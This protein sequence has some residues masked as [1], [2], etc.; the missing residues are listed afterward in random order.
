MAKFKVGD[1]VKF[2]GVDKWLLALCKGDG[3]DWTDH[4][5]RTEV[6]EVSEVDSIDNFIPINSYK[7]KG[8]PY[9]FHED[10]LKLVKEAEK[11]AKSVGNLHIKNVIFNDMATIVFWSDGDKTVVLCRRGDSYD[12]EKGVA[13]ACAKKLFGNKNGYHAREFRF[14]KN[15]TASPDR[16]ELLRIVRRGCSNNPSCV[17]CPC[18]HQEDNTCIVPF[19]LAS[20]DA[21]RKMAKSFSRKKKEVKNG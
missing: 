12:A 14:V 8:L 17:S 21:L 11:D 10:W 3:E 18:G 19:K 5:S 20:T 7:L 15:N 16:E 9:I 2:V 13:M 6:Y 1:K 4:V